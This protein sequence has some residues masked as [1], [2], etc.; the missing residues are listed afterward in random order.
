MGMKVLFCGLKNEYGSPKKGLSFEY[1][2]FFGTLQNMAGIEAESFPFDEVMTQVGRD[3]MNKRLIKKVEEEKP[4]LLFCFLFTEEIKKETIEYITK[5]TQTKTFNWF[6]DDHWRFPVFSK[7]WAPFFT[8]VSTTDGLAYKKY[9]QAG[10]RN[11]VKT[12]WAA[13]QYLF[14]PQEPLKNLRRYNITFFG[15]KYGNRGEY[16]QTLQS[17]GLPAEGIGRGWGDGL[18]SDIQE[19]LNIYSFSK[20]N[21]NFSETP[22]HGFKNKLNLLTKLFI[23]KE[24]G[25][26]KFDGQN[27]FSNAQAAIGTQRRTIKARTFEVPA[28]GGFLLTGPSDDPLEEYL[29]PGKE[30]VV[31][32]DIGELVEK[33]KYYLEH[34]PER[35]AI[36]NAG[37]ARVTREHT[38]DQR[39][40][41]IFQALELV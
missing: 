37:Y 35:R 30:V 16:I 4:D 20:I 12:Q 10:I 39:F 21:L 5:K 27:F 18:G 14:T 26:Y 41:K 29:L 19:M 3:E 6:G 40:I 9:L 24:L 23:K 15:Q 33:C 1:K 7:H 17:S 38:Y 31:F 2:H 36:A 8:L 22:Y 32:N 25:K 11:V 28:C 34:E 13:N